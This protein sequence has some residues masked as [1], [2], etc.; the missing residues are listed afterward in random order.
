MQLTVRAV[1]IDADLL[2][3]SWTLAIAD[4]PTESPGRRGSSADLSI[5]KVNK[6][7]KRPPAKELLLKACQRCSER[8]YRCLSTIVGSRTDNVASLASLSHG[9]GLQKQTNKRLCLGGGGL[10]P[11]WRVRWFWIGW[12]HR[13]CAGWETLAPGGISDVISVPEG[14]EPR[15]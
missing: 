2:Y 12:G 5:V 13:W 14:Q 1:V 6:L 15:Q 10:S 4:A 7:C 11:C 9:F 3:Q 8:L